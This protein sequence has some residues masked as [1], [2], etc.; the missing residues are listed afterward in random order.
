MNKLSQREKRINL[1]NILYRYF[2]IK[3]SFSDII[4][5][6]YDLKE[7]LFVSEEMIKELEAILNYEQSLISLIE[8]KLKM[9]WKF[10]RLDNY[11]KAILLYCGFEIIH[12]KTAKSIVINE[13]MEIL[14]QYEINLHEHRYINSI[15]D[16]L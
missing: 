6:T 14:K 3:A 13:A 16:Q 11:D 5:Y 15:L 12:K 2:V 9:G 1:I 7:E 8:V 10:N 4:Q